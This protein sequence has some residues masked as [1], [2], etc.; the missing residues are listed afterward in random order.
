MKKFYFLNVIIVVCIG[1]VSSCKKISYNVSQYNETLKILPCLKEIH[2]T[3]IKDNKRENLT[4]I[5]KSYGQKRMINTEENYK[6]LKAKDLLI[7]LQQNNISCLD[8]INYF[9]GIRIPYPKEIQFDVN[10][11]RR[12]TFS[13]EFSKMHKYESHRIIFHQKN[14]V[15]LNELDKLM[16]G[17]EKIIKRVEI[18]EG[19]TYLIS[20]YESYH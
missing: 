13:S 1:A 3:L 17:T 18:E 16:L 12:T 19:I 7:F 2:S 14:S 4:N 8:S 15:I 6:L 11:F 5:I 20:Q 10:E 9:K